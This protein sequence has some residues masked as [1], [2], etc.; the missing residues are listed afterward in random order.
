MARQKWSARDI[1]IFLGDT[2]TGF[3]LT[4]LDANVDDAVVAEYTEN[5]FL[6][7]M[8]DVSGKQGVQVENTV[9]NMRVTIKVARGATV[10]I[11]RLEAI[12]HS[13]QQLPALTGRNMGSSTS[14]FIGRSAVI[15]S[16]GQWQGGKNP[17]SITYTFLCLDAT[18]THGGQRILPV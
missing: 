13:K 10:D 9:S 4:G 1:T 6:E 5:L 8:N 18:I 12:A 17:Q 3:P 15:E 2:L 14:S 11:A 16:I 7:P